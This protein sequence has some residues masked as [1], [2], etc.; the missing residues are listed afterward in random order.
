VILLCGIPSESPLTLV[1]NALAAESVP[2]VEFNQRRFADM[3]LSFSIANGRLTGELRVA[4]QRFPLE[5]FTGVYTRMMDDRLLPEL[6]DAPALSPLRIHCRALHDATQHWMEVA[7][8][9]VVN[10]T[11]PMTTNGSKPLQAQMIQAAGFAVADTL[12]TND[13]EAVREFRASKRRIVCKSTSGVRSI[14]RE[15]SDDD[16]QRLDQIRWC[17]VQFQEFIPGTD[18][19]VHVVDTRVF[20]TRI[21][22]ASTDYRYAAREG[23]PAQLDPLELPTDIAARTVAMAAALKLPFAGIDLRITPDGTAYCFEVNPSPGFSY[24]EARTGQP[25]AAAV[26]SYLAGT[27]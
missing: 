13:P 27:S 3:D 2:Y 6:R 20:A 18:V 23:E 8:T 21:T 5:D 4:D 9:R 24:Y 26:A 7:P 17:P 15:V 14:V 25:I 16:M 12:V 19:R 11:A 1:R 10:R 22:S